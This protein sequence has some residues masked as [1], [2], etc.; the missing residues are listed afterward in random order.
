VD[1]YEGEGAD[2]GVGSRDE[3]H[4]GGGGIRGG[5]GRGLGGGGDGGEGDDENR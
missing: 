2:A 1:A 5:R 4:V 3:R